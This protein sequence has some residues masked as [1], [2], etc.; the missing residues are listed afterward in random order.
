MDA[1]TMMTVVRILDSDIEALL[2][3]RELYLDSE[4]EWMRTQKFAI[5]HTVSRLE[6]L[7]D[8]FQGCIESQINAYEISQGM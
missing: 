4:E 6:N 1:N 2:T 5:E 8:Y 7:S 3:E